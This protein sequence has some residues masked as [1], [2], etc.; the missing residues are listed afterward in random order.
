M[1]DYINESGDIDFDKL[2]T[3]ERDEYLKMLNIVQSSE[4]TL[5]DF[6]K[7]VR[8]VR[9]SLENTLV[10]TEDFIYSPIFTFLKR[11]N[12]KVAELKARLKNYI[13]FE[14]FFGRPELAKQ[15]LDVY[16]KR[17]NL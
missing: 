13:V 11:P 8:S 17:L 12:P 2:N 3:V 15:A 16:K 9:E 5:E 7:F 1:D 10:D 4:V 6:K 14:R